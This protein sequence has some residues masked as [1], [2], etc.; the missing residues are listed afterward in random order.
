M[1]RLQ[2]ELTPQQ[3]LV[4]KINGKIDFSYSLVPSEELERYAVGYHNLWTGKNPSLNCQNV[5]SIVDEATQDKYILGHIFGGWLD[6]KTDK[7]Y[8]D[9]STT[10]DSLEWA[11]KMAK[12]RGELAIY[13]RVL[14]IVIEVE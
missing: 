2:N 4:A 12:Q 9:I 11:L 6:T 8:V 5:W 14:G 13:D 7:Y 10:Y 1:A 3:L